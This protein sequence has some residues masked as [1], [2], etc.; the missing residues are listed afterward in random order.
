MSQHRFFNALCSVRSAVWASAGVLLASSMAASAATEIKV[1]HSLNPHNKDVF[2]SLIKDF[3]KQQ[4]DIKV[5]LNAFDSQEAVDAALALIDAPRNKPHLVQ[6]DD[7]R[8]PD[9]IA[10]RSY[11]QPMYALL[12]KHP[13]KDA[14]W[15]LSENNSY[16]RDTK[17]R[18]LGF[19]YMVDIPVMYYNIKSFKTANI[20]PAQP[21]RSW[22]GLQGQLVELAN[23]GSRKC[24][25]TSDQPVS[26]N[27]E[28]LA[29]VN[30]QL[31]TMETGGKAKKTPVFHFDTMYIRHLSLM[32]S[33][34]RTELMVKPEFDTVAP[35]RFANNECGVLLS[36]S[37]NMGWFK[38]TRGLDFSVSGLPYYPEVT[39]TPG[40]P[41]AS[42]SALWSTKGHSKE[43]DSASAQ[44]LAWLASPENAA[45]WYQS[46]GFLPLTQQAFA[47][48]KDSYYKGMGDWR[49]LVEVYSNKP[50][51]AGRGFRVNNYPKIKTMFH[52]TLDRALNGQQP[53]V[54]A[55][56]FASTE[57]GKI[58]AER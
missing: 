41:F 35:H 37:G 47:Q 5:V 8:A 58:M 51:A 9:D 15:F 56:K 54:T 33:W 28:N 2:E 39:K 49:Q 36:G 14:K 7:Q 27:L 17:G 29:A 13:I 55:L 20:N 50:S 38:D 23:N 52:E 45:K 3:N 12:A 19:P 1:W 22:S 57:A 44:L 4:Q 10:K 43:D 18:L 11:I 53:A 31:Y 32:I 6:L 30:N 48:T 21:E 25:L 40:A 16:L 24:P 46:T 34:V 26:I 42:G